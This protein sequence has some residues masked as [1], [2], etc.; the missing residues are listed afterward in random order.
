[1]CI[2]L[3]VLHSV[4]LC[5][6]LTSCCCLTCSII[7]QVLNPNGPPVGGASKKQIKALDKKKYTSEDTTIAKEDA[8]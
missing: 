5:C 3:V 6:T 7:S 4:L 1:M 8:V 2:A